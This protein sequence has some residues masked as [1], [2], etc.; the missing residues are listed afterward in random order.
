[1]SFDNDGH[2]WIVDNTGDEV[3]EIADP[4]DGNGIQSRQPARVRS[5]T[6]SGVCP[7]TSQIQCRS[8]R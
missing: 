6:P 1:M 5:T 8:H 2:L 7:L 4:T 3:F